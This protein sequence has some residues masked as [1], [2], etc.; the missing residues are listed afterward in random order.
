MKIA[1]DYLFA[2]PRPLV[3][4][5]LLDPT[6]LAAVL[7]GAERLDLTGEN[8]Y[9]GQLKIKVG[10][11]QGDF[12]GKVRLEDIQ[13][14]SSYRMDIDGRGAQ[15]FVKAR[16]VLGLAEEGSGTRLTYDADAQVGGRIASVGQRLIESS[17]RAIVK[18]SLEGLDA[19]IQARAAAARAVAAAGGSA[20]AAAAAAAA[21]AAAAVDKPSQAAFAAGVAKEVARD[22]IPPAA[23]YALV[24]L[25]VA[26]LVWLVM[27]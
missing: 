20:E 24:V 2:A 19:A 23:R 12:L 7:P 3:W 1:G 8:E 26:L 22:L 4:E 5:A 17:A 21:V 10:P 16:A 18:Q 9:E 14:P 11:V 6:V 25:V 27:R 15:G 13:P